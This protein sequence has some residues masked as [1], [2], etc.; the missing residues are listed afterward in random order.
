M[1]ASHPFFRLRGAVGSIVDCIGAD[2]GAGASD[3][4]SADA[5]DAFLQPVAS[6]IWR[7]AHPVFL[8]CA[9][10][11]RKASVATS[12]VTLRDCP[13]DHTHARICRVHLGQLVISSAMFNAF[14][15]AGN[16]YTGYW[17]RYETTH[18]KWWD[19][20]VASVKGWR[21]DVWSD[22]NPFLDDYVGHPIMGSITDYLWIQNDPKSMTLEQS[23]TWPYWRRMLR[24]LAFSTCLQLRME[25]RAIRRGGNWPQWRSLFLRRER[26]SLPR[27]RRDGWSW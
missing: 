26:Q 10:S 1:I 18:G 14:Q 20:Y 4:A 6:Q 2:A 21:W 27:T 5:P 23:N 16:L 13:Y 17:Y 25:A 15:N 3:D 22:N 12:E 19:R 9:S 24:A 8:L 7:Q 11:H